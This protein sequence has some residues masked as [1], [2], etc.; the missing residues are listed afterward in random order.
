MVVGAGQWVEEVGF[1]RRVLESFQKG[2][3]SRRRRLGREGTYCLKER[4]GVVRVVL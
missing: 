3:G 4:G 2:G 1:S